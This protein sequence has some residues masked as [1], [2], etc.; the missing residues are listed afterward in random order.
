MDKITIVA[1]ETAID[2][3]AW[4]C[5]H[6]N[7]QDTDISE[8][9]LI[10]SLERQAVFFGL[11]PGIIQGGMKMDFGAIPGSKYDFARNASN[12]FYS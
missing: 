5:P 9:M 2:L 7:E 8:N 10:P 6:G 11:N 3:A 12:S 4:N 1:E